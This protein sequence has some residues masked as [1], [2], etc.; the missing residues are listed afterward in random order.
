M[1]KSIGAKPCVFPAPVWCIGSYDADGS[2]NVMTAAWGGICCSKPPAVTVSLRQATYTYSNIMA[3]KA[4]TVSVPSREHIVA[5]DY[6]GMASGRDFDKFAATGMT[7][8]GSELVDAPYIAEF[9]M[10]LECSLLHTFEIGLHT[11]FV[12]E[13]V[14]VKVEESVLDADGKPDM[15][16]A[17]VFAFAPEA[18]AYHAVGEPLGK[19]FDIG[20]PLLKQGD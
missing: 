7:P 4:Y 11:M 6:F 5:A 12:G 3:R 10:V 16:R 14:D 2:P 9:P 1:K 8:T 20:K 15:G 17:G 19:A 13:V 18:R